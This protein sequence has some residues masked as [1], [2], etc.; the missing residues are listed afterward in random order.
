MTYVKLTD[1]IPAPYTLA[2]LRADNP[3]VSFPRI[4][5]NDTLASYG[6]FPCTPVGEPP[7]HDPNVERLDKGYAK[8]NGGWQE[9]WNLTPLT[10]EEKAAN[11]AA[12]RD[13]A[14]LTRRQFILACLDAGLLSEVDAVTAATG[15]WPATFDAAL[16]GLSDRQKAEARVEWAA[17]SSIWRNAPLLSTVQATAGVTD[18]QLDALFGWAG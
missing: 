6:V 18:A 7:A 3:S 12:W 10:T 2:Q 17:A 16:I 1:G 14:T 15:G 8:V 5:S 11:L 13:T 9:A 4:P